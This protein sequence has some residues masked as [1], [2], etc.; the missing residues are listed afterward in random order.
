[1]TCSILTAREGPLSQDVGLG[2]CV[3]RCCRKAANRLSKGVIKLALLVLT[4][5]AAITASTVPMNVASKRT[6]TFQ[7]RSTC[8]LVSLH[9]GPKKCKNHG[10]GSNVRLMASTNGFASI[11][12]LST[13]WRSTPIDVTTPSEIPCP[14]DD[15]NS[16]RMASRRRTLNQPSKC[17][18]PVPDTCTLTLRPDLP[19]TPW[20]SSVVTSVL[21]LHWVTSTI[22]WVNLALVNSK[23]RAMNCAIKQ[24]RPEHAAE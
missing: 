12:S 13:G 18:C 17:V 11:N 4:I 10:T 23:T 6:L 14:S 8:D 9:R 5:A 20:G 1:M 15:C 21:P 16:S 22:W 3:R 7:S 19:T 24:P 2:F